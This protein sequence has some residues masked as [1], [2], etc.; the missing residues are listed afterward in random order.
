MEPGEPEFTEDDALSPGDC[1]LIRSAITGSRWVTYRAYMKNG[2]EVR[3][4]RLDETL[5]AMHP[6]LY[7]VA[8]TA[9]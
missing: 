1:V 9:P 3:R 2:A 8:P 6:A 7:A 4:E 5:Y